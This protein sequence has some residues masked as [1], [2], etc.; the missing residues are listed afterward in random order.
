VQDGTTSRAVEYLYKGVWQ[1]LYGIN[2]NGNGT[3]TA[4]NYGNGEKFKITLVPNEASQ[5]PTDWMIR[6]GDSTV[7]QNLASYTDGKLTIRTALGALA[8][9]PETKTWEM[10][11]EF[12]KE[13]VV[14]I[15]M[16]AAPASNPAAAPAAA[17]SCPPGTTPDPV[18]GGCA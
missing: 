3:V 5:E 18:N 2:L 13:T 6:L 9:N 8:Y 14:E 12:G 7:M 17:P 11:T 16:A 15:P 4:E 1:T 10:M